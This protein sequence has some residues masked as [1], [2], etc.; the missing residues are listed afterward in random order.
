MH[1]Q[2]KQGQVI[3]EK[4]GDEI[5]LCRDGARK[6]KRRLELNLSRHAK[7]YKGLLY[8]FYTY[9][10]KER[11]AK[12]GP[13]NNGAKLIRMG[14]EEAEVVNNTFA[15]VLNGSLSSSVFYF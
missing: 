3:L 2:W 4:Q 15:S 11:K 8:G 6:V 5:R 14:E 12:E 9:I 7:N 1:R 10:N 13:I